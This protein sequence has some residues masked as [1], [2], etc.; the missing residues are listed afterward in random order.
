MKII[1]KNK[2][3]YTNESVMTGNLLARQKNRKKN[4]QGFT[5]P[6]YSQ[7]SL[8]VPGRFWTLLCDG[9]SARR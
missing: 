2:V 7:A 1:E 4:S 5:A 9:L 8:F 6:V 3:R